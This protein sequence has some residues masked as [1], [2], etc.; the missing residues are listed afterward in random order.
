MNKRSLGDM[1]N[2]ARKRNHR[3]CSWRWKSLRTILLSWKKQKSLW[4]IESLGDIRI[5][6]KEE[7]Q[8]CWQHDC[9]CPMRSLMGHV[10]NYKEALQALHSRDQAVTGLTAVPVYERG[11]R[12][13]PVLI[14]LR[15]MESWVSFLQTK[16]ELTCERCTFVSIHNT[17][18]LFFLYLPL[19]L[20]LLVF[21]FFSF[22]FTYA[23]KAN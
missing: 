15:I 21:L 18:S 11:V 17:F 19:S 9:R 4:W 12:L 13:V 20:S 5:F 16:T 2:P 10:I 14:Q 7:W 1:K 6:R 23:T 3:S 22:S 8:P